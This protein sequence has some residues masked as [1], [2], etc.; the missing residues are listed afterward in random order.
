PACGSPAGS[1]PA[2]S[3]LLQPASARPLITAVTSIF[4]CEDENFGI[5][6]TLRRRMLPAC[7]TLSYLDLF[8]Y[9]RKFS[10]PPSHR[11]HGEQTTIQI[12]G[13]RLGWIN[14]ND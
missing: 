1:L 8:R 2:E 13:P 3:V 11:G 7:F 14:G 12:L 10:R 5:A 6:I 4:K 9:L